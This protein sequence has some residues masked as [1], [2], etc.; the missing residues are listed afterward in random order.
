[1]LEQSPV[2]SQAPQ[3]LK[4][5]DDRIPHIEPLFEDATFVSEYSRLTKRYAGPDYEPI[6]K[7]TL[8]QLKEVEQPRILELGPGP[9][10]I[11]ITLAKRRKDARVT[12]V[13]ISSTYVEIANQN[14]AHEGV[15]DRV[16]FRKGDACRLEDFPDGSMDAVISNQ[17]FHYW[18][19]PEN[20]LREVVRVLKPNGVFCIGDDRRDLTF[21]ASLIVMLTKWFLTANVRES[22]MRSLQ[23]SFTS[24]EVQAILEHSDLHGHA[25]V[26][27]YPRMFFV[28]GRLKK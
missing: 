19:P 8:A 22:W 17:S 13:D 23:G 9:G 15:D 4:T 28:Q 18:E 14:A 10:W 21:M 20:V 27:L 5:N 11:G 7:Y 24:K 16:D 3:Q 1:M 26:K 12:G 25:E 6:L 2:T